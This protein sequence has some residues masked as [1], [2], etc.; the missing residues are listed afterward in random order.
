V[1]TSFLD[2]IARLDLPHRY[3]VF[4]LYGSA[5]IGRLRRGH[6]VGTGRLG[7]TFGTSTIQGHGVHGSM[8][9]RTLGGES[10]WP[11]RADPYQGRWP[12]GYL[13]LGLEATHGTG[14]VTFGDTTVGSSNLF[15]LTFLLTAHLRYTLNPTLVLQGALGTGFGLGTLKVDRAAVPSDKAIDDPCKIDPDAGLDLNA[16]SAAVRCTITNSFGFFQSYPVWISGGVELWGWLHVDAVYQHTSYVTDK[17]QFAPP[18]LE[19]LSLR[20]GINIY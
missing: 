15:A 11:F 16:A 6:L 13:G 3:T 17:V 18:A 1:T 4:L 19:D 9:S 5:D 14:D 10:L 8:L 2:E 20:L 12:L 7:R